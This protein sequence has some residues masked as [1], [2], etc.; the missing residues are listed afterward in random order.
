MEELHIEYG[1]CPICD[2]MLNEA[3]ET[4]CGYIGQS[5]YD[6]LILFCSKECYEQALQNSGKESNSF[7]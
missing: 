1:R 3:D 5:E 4:K 6:G 2:A 7:R